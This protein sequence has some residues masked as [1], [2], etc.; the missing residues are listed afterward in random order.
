MVE[1]ASVIAVIIILFGA[2]IAML[3]I[4]AARYKKVPP[5]KAMVVYG[6]RMKPGKL[7]T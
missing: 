5:D 2:L 4:Y 3:I 1:S 7:R 6:R